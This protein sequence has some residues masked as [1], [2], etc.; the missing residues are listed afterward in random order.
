LE[1]SFKIEMLVE[2]KR[3]GAP[4]GRNIGSPDGYRDE[5]RGKRKTND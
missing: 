4:A 3:F 5:T 1:S 2:G